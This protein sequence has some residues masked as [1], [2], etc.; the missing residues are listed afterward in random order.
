MSAATA[1]RGATFR[2]LHSR[3]FAWVWSGQTISQ[4]G[5]GAYLT[6][7]AWAA[8]QL[9]GSAT[10]VGA[11]L[12]ASTIPSLVFVLVGGVAADRYSRRRIMLL[13]DAGRALTLGVVAVL[14]LLGLLHL[15]HL[16]TLAVIFGFVRGFFSPAYQAVIPELVETDALASANGLTGLSQQIGGLIGPGLAAWLI[17]VASANWAFAFDALTFV[18]AALCVLPAGALD[19]PTPALAASDDEPDTRP[20]TAAPARQ[21]GLRGV[22][23]ESRDGLTYIL[24]SGWLMATIVLPFFANP[25]LTASESVALPKLVKDVWGRG[26]WLF[27]LSGSI[28]AVGAIIGMLV[29]TR[30]RPTRRGVTC[31]IMGAIAGVAQLAYA[32]PISRA[33]EPVIV[34]GVAL[35]LGFTLSAFNLIWLTTVQE[36]VPRDK[37][38]RVF[39]LDQL[40]SLALIPVGYA[41]AGVISDRYS[42]IW[43]FVIAGALEII[44]SVIGLSLRSVRELR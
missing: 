6:A 3:R 9:T 26:A 35:V 8:L 36:L 4:L 41:V 37:L 38:G 25:M 2:A 7:L 23:A 20:H 21:R 28:F 14:G 17:A 30:V 32:L 19:S 33:M 10:A 18:V 13:S 15:W 40:G 27:G 39:A 31:F 5:N 42:P 22:L 1:R 16:L 34:G 11:L 43:V 12:I 24:A 29:Y 44:T